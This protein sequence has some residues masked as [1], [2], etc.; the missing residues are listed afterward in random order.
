MWCSL[1]STGIPTVV[2]RDVMHGMGFSRQL[3]MRT[4]MVASHPLR[5][6]RRSQQLC[7]HPHQQ[8][9]LHLSLHPSR[10]HR[11]L[12][13]RL[14]HRP[15]HQQRSRRHCQ[16]AP[17]HFYRP[18]WIQQQQTSH[19]MHLHLHRLWSPLLIQLSLRRRSQQAIQPSHQQKTQLLSHPH[20]HPH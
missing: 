10:H 2:M 20:E 15:P 9:S 17:R 12:M 4:A 16:R 1:H 5:H 3:F 8:K 11:H 6:R 13:H 14:L 18:L 7:R 19:H